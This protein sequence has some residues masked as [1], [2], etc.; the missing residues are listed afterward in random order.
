M[1]ERFIEQNHHQQQQQ[2]NAIDAVQEENRQARNESE[3]AANKADEPRTITNIYYDCLERIFDELELEDLLMVAQTCKRLQIAAA[4]KFGD[5]YGK[6]KIYLCPIGVI[7]NVEVHRGNFVV[8][9]N[10]EMCLPFLRIFGAK[11]S[12]LEAVEWDDYA[13]EEHDHVARYVNQYCA[14][15]LESIEINSEKVISRNVVQ[16]PFKNVGKVTLFGYNVSGNALLN[17]T[18]CFPNMHHLVLRYCRIDETTSMNALFIPNLTHLYLCFDKERNDKERDDDVTQLTIA[19]AL[20]ANAHLPSL[21]IYSPFE[22]TLSMLLDLIQHN[23]AIT[24]LAT[25]EARCEVTLNELNRLAVEH[26]MIV[27]LNLSGYGLN[28]DDAINFVGQMKS[29][30]RIKF[31]TVNDRTECDRLLN[32]LHGEWKSNVSVRFDDI[33]I[34]LH[35]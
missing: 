11:I 19:N 34:E 28:T 13:G 30:K 6:M 15:T 14:D 24:K 25:V 7:T 26:P 1:A 12:D 10:L 27:E 29:L 17:L 16:K 31:R 8:V 32:Q 9:S 2:Q 18:D 20:K 35:R 22:L 21:E 4:A 3:A 33:Y 23:P 5:Q